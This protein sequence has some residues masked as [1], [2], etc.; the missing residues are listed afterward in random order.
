MLQPIDFQP[1]YSFI[2]NTFFEPTDVNHLS[3]VKIT[4]ESLEKLCKDSSTEVLCC[5]TVYNEPAEALLY[6]LAGIKNN[7]DHLMRIGKSFLASQI[8]ICIIFDGRERMSDSAANLIE[9]L[10]LY[11]PQKVKSGAGV[12]IFDGI[13]DS[14][15]LKHC[16]ELFTDSVLSDKH[17]KHIYWTAQE[18]NQLNSS[19]YIE[20]QGKNIEQIF[21]RVL[22]CIKE[23]NAGKLN[24]H[25]WFFMAFS[26]YLSPQYCIQMDT[27]TVPTASCIDLLWSYMEQHENVAG[28]A[29]FVLTPKPP[30]LL[31]IVSTWQS[32]YFSI[33]KVLVFPPEIAAGYL[34]ILPGQLSML[35][36]KALYPQ[37]SDQLVKEEQTFPLKRYFRG[38][39]KL[40]L[41]ESN[42]FL[43][44]DRII[45]FEI[46][47][48]SSSSWKIALVPSAI[49]ITDACQSLSELLRQRRRWINSIFTVRLWMLLKSFTYLRNGR[50]G[51]IDRFRFVGASAYHFL[52]ALLTW[53]SPATV[54]GSTILLYEYTKD[55][56]E[57]HSPLL[58]PIIDSFF[59]MELFSLTT[60]LVLAELYKKY[61]FLL[62]VN[63]ASRLSFSAVI[64]GSL[65]CAFIWTGHSGLLNLPLAFCILPALLY[66]SIALHGQWFLNRS[67][68]SVIL[69]FLIDLPVSLVL[70]SYAFHNIHDV[71]WG[72]KGLTRGSQ[73]LK[74]SHQKFKH[75]FVFTW[76]LSNLLLTISIMNFSNVQTFKILLYAFYLGFSIFS[77]IIF[78]TKEKL[79]LVKWSKR[80]K[81]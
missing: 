6:S 4:E 29:S 51:L 75:I 61:K 69:Y 73:Q 7:I 40:G 20:E 66:L 32:G 3:S 10:K 13:L 15:K 80:G 31:D 24:S 81:I 43:A 2:P 41:F 27:G 62:I 39:R 34:S 76:L 72:T 28:T 37:R 56:L 48:N 44:E 54:Y 79:S 55:I 22:L 64:I 68:K 50:I 17:L 42:M 58:V 8:T 71:S 16:T 25:W 21:P 52:T 18:Y 9:E 23:E 38:L 5:I 65:I 49:A 63:I 30:R 70:Q 35:R 19:G 78:M 67:W 60:I 59:I 46:V 74:R 77:G 14:K 26:R 12:H 33:E 47:T 53:F 45:G 36:W 57:T 11:D 1:D